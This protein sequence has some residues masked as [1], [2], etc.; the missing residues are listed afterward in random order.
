MKNIYAKQL[1]NMPKD[2]IVR[3]VFDQSHKSLIAVK[4]G[5]VL[6]GITYRLF[7]RQALAEIAFCAVS[8]SEQVKGYGSRLMSKLKTHARDAEGVTHLIT[9]A[10][11]NAV[12]Y[13]SKLGFSKEILLEREKWS[14][15]IKEY[16][17]GTLM[18]SLLHPPARALPADFGAAIRGQR[19]AVEAKIKELTCSHVVHPG[20]SHFRD[21]PPRPGATR[22]PLPV[23][24]IPGLAAAG[25][26]P[27]P[28]RF[29]LVAPG[30]GSGAPT[31]ENLH[32][33][34]KGV[35]VSVLDHPDGWPFAEPVDG[36]E[37]SD[38]YDIVKEPVDLRMIGE[39]LELGDYYVTLEVFAADFR[40]MF[41][42]CRLY[43]APDTPYFKCANRL[44]AFFDQRV[45]AGITWTKRS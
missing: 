44:E 30:C 33:F 24:S 42:N 8:S 12:G 38:Y 7:S 28:L 37:V 16:D 35:H 36:E 17:G 6:G 3:L 20:L 32:R 2:Y 18:E 23:A 26:T 21:A 4:E 39:R 29:R 22:P 10:D 19:G 25:W 11:N 15:Y 13:F 27:A 43:N 5:A 1:P 14:G 34:M 31:R 40:R 45:A 9:F 41:H